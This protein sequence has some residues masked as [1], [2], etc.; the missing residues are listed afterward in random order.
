MITLSIGRM[1]VELT[2]CRPVVKLLASKILVCHQV[3]C[4]RSMPP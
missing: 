3:F 1:V 4:A 2:A